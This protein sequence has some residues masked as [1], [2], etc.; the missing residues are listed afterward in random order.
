M[1]E[2]LNS[3]IFI[4]GH[5]RSGTS[6]LMRVLANSDELL[7]P[8][9]RGKLNVLR[10]LLTEGGDEKE[11]N[12]DRASRL[13]NIIELTLSASKYEI[14]RDTLSKRIS[15]IKEVG[16]KSD[17]KVILDTIIDFTGK[18]AETN[19]K[20]WIEKNHN[21]EFYWN[22][23]LVAF[24]NPY[25]LFMLRDPRDVWA[26]WK[27]ECHNKGIELSEKQTRRNI[28]QHL[29][30]EIIETGFGCGRFNN[31]HEICEYY[32]VPDMNMKKLHESVTN[33][34]FKGIH[35]E[36]VNVEIVD[37]KSY[38]YSNDDVG[39]FAWNYK[40][41]AERAHWLQKNYGNK[42]KIIRY[43]NL[44]EFPGNVVNDIAKFCGFSISES[45]EPKD[46]G[47]HWKGNSSF[48]SE[49][50]GVSSDSVGRWK[51]C[52]PGNEIEIILNVAMPCYV[53]E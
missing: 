34:M 10:R 13:Q 25:L 52:L 4:S 32:R 19:F 40:I 45:L 24:T 11:N 46:M 16:F 36:V 37:L 50:K 31:L 48:V 44:V 49:F 14:F 47:E 27:I 6:L 21:L 1:E 9:G 51:D 20:F 15:E 38:Q 2:L 23:A 5:T 35:S 43:E 18:Q 12:F 28:Q 29:I 3:P 8:P 22:R 42:V 41:I 26:S 30:E 17:V 7:N 33:V 53:N 39:G